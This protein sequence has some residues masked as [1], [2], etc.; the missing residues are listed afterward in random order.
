[1][2][3]I[4]LL[5][6]GATVAL[7]VES[8][9]AISPEAR[10]AAVLELTQAIE[11][12]S[13]HR[14]ILDD[15]DA[16]CGAGEPCV[17]A[18]RSRT[19]TFDVVLVQMVLGPL[20]LRVLAQRIGPTAADE[21]RSAADVKAG[22]PL[23]ETAAA[24]ARELFPKGPAKPADVVAAP[25]PIVEPSRTPAWIAFGTAA[26]LTGVGV[27]LGVSSHSAIDTLRQTGGGSASGIE[28]LAGQASGQAVVANILFLAAAGAM[29]TGVGLWIAP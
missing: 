22:A 6:I 24:I 16:S 14:V 8:V 27:A 26:A 28:D 4:G 10:R 12:E 23:G 3:A 18:I 5:L 25:P 19:S 29:I 1:M 15:D 17:S 21:R 7:P 20:R 11:S 13:G 2:I 9:G